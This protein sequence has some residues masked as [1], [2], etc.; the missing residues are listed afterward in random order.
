MNENKN[1][2]IHNQNSWQ[3]P[4]S[5]YLFLILVRIRTCSK[6]HSG[7]EAVKSNECFVCKEVL[8]YYC[9][10]WRSDARQTPSMF[11]ID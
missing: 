10:N 7:Y 1:R 4:F 8:Y 11:N 2:N 5:D 9:E 6:S 3:V